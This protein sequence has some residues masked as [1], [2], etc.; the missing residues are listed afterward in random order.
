[1]GVTL[2]AALLLQA[3]EIT[4][5]RHRLGRRWLR[6]PV[7]IMILVSV[8]YQGI[9][10]ILLAIPSIGAWDSYRTGIQ[11]SYVDSA[12]LVMSASM[13]A[14]TIAYLLIR[15]ERSAPQPSRDDVAVTLKALDWRW[16]ACCCIPLAIL[17][18]QGRGY[19]G[20]GPAT[21]GGAPLS[22]D[23]A[24]EFFVILMVLTALSFLLKHGTRL[25]FP[26]LIIQCLLLA[27]AGE[28]S[29]VIMDAIT[30]VLLLAHAGYQ[31]PRRQVR[32]AAALTLIAV[33]AITGE[34][35]HQGRTL[36]HED[37]SLATRV[38]VLGSSLTATESDGSGP[39]L[40]PQA[41]VRLDGIDFAGGILQSQSLGQPRL[42]P[43][44][45]PESLLLAVPSALWP[46]KLDHG[47]N[48]NPTYLEIESF[49]LQNVNFL[50]TLPGL[51]IGFLR[52]PWLIAFLAFLGLLAGACERLLFRYRTPA[53]LILLAGAIIAALTY[54]AGLPNMLVTLR[55]AAT[56]AIVVKLI[57]VVR[58]RRARRSS[59][60]LP[61]P[62]SFSTQASAQEVTASSNSSQRS[63]DAEV[64][65][66]ARGD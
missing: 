60:Y 15:P 63:P 25:F 65:Q 12:T 14:F 46:A 56:V 9:S 13:L 36:Y 20:G 57:E 51:Y 54:E 17:T 55:S 23:L 6:H 18:Y 58:V 44:Y 41:A 37:S 52:A 26:V 50:P 5:L 7:S 8:A 42:S 2:T 3:V 34:R 39:G 10:P 40:V 64:R 47:S 21:G 22:V 16:L 53:R 4:L 11:Q 48:L 66:L 32:A 27:A 35:V 62:W 33:L 29:P 38:A 19:N 1:M 24:S 43:S 31:L 61:S 45:V 28:R 30:L 59:A 49:G